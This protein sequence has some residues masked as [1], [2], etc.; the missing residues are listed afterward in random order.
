MKLNKQITVI[1]FLCAIF[2]S[3]T[4]NRTTY[5]DEKVRLITVERELPF[6]ADIVWKKIFL[7]YGGAYKFNPG[8][9]KSDYV[10]EYRSAEVGAKRYM[11]QDNEAKKILYEQIEEIDHEDKMMLFKIYDAKG[12]PINTSVTYGKSQLISVDAKK[13]LFKVNFYYKTKPGFLAAFVNSRLEENFN[14]ML[15]GI[16]HHLLT[17]EL[18]TEETFERIVENYR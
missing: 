10:G 3:C 11:H 2:T 1:L 6:S 9:I 13:T 7:D 4:S 8:V 17:G 15:I 12:I 14:N 5:K 16:E 18:I